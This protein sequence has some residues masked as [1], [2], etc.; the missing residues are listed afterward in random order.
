MTQIGVTELEST[1]TKLTKLKDS[2][3]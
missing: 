2:V 1:D 3:R